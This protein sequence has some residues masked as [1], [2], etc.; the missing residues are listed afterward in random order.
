[1]EC[2]GDS[3]YDYCRFLNGGFEL[4][5]THRLPCGSDGKESACNGGA[6]SLIPGSG[7]AP[8]DENVYPLWYS[9]LKNSM[10]RG[11]W[12]DTVHGVSKSW[13]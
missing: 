9:C 2:L 3:F 1:M 8:G 6:L 7:R 11:A 10:V 4:S 5:E 12:W 13:T